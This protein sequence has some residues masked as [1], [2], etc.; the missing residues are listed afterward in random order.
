MFNELVDIKEDNLLQANNEI[1]STLL[2]DNTTK[3]N[4]I[5]ASDN[6]E[7]YGEG[8]TF[9]QE[10]TIDKITGKYGDVI[11]PRSRKTSN[12]KLKRIKDN[13]EVFTPSWICN[14]QNNLADDA[15][16]G[17]KNVFNISEQKKWIAN[18]SKIEFTKD[19]TWQD[20][21]KSIRLEIS[22]GEAPYLV[23]RYDTVTGKSIKISDRI[24]LLDRKLRVLSENV[25]LE[26][27]WIDWSIIAVKSIYGYDLQGDNILLARENILYTYIDYY[28]DKFNKKPSLD[29]IKEI[30]EIISWNIWQM[31]GLKF[32]IPRSCKNEI[33]KEYTLFGDIET[34]TECNGCKT[35]NYKDH[36]GIYCKIMN[37]EKNKTVKFYTL[38]NKK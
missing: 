33:I 5:W 27:E 18:E 30:A 28:K 32:V 23:S 37:W 17:K 31:D 7:G 8:F 12:E 19:K 24:G 9:F 38:V 35:N 15:W 4:I 11:K 13:G 10:I 1:L 3:K 21:V 20:Y 14:E 36:N 26:N 25:D 2:F 29:L 16:F 6:Y 22:C 34:K